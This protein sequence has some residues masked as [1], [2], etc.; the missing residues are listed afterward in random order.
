MSFVFVWSLWNLITCV[1]CTCHTHINCEERS[2]SDRSICLHTVFHEPKPS[3]ISVF[4]SIFKSVCCNRV[5]IF[6]NGV[7]SVMLW[8]S[9]SCHC[10]NYGTKKK[11][12]GVMVTNRA[13]VYVLNKGREEKSGTN[14][15]INVQIMVL[16]TYIAPNTREPL[17]IQVTHT[18]KEH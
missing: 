8:I 13:I 17:S 12:N 2:Q 16:L 15:S 10:H 9:P 4:A 14:T 18:V 6:F 11:P 1:Y 3:C 5:K 7:Y